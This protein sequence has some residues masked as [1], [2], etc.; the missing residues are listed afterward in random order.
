MTTLTASQSSVAEGETVRFNMLSDLSPVSL[1]Q[2]GSS[3]FA[4]YDITGGVSADDYEFAG[5]GSSD[6]QL[7]G[8][9][10]L[11]CSVS[12][13]FLIDL[14]VDDG[15]RLVFRWTGIRRVDSDG[16]SHVHDTFS[17]PLTTT[18]TVAHT[19]PTVSLSACVYNGVAGCVPNT[20]G[21]SFSVQEAQVYLISLNFDST[22]PVLGAYSYA[23]SGDDIT[24]EDY[25]AS[26][27][28]GVISRTRGG[29]FSAFINLRTD[30]LNEGRETLVYSLTETPFNISIGNS[31]T[32]NI[33]PSDPTTVRIARKSGE[34]G[35]VDE[36]G[37]GR[38][39]VT[40]VG[41]RPTAD[42][43][44]PFTIAGQATAVSPLTITALAT[45][46]EIAV[47][48]TRDANL[49]SGEE[50][51]I[52]LDAPDEDGNGGPS[53]GG[54]GGI[55]VDADND[56]A[57]A[58]IIDTATVGIAAVAAEVDEPGTAR[59]L[60]SY[61]GGRPAVGA[62]AVNVTV[63]YTV[64]G[65]AAAADYTDAGGG[66][67]TFAAGAADAARTI[68]I[69]VVD[70]SLA[71]IEET[72]TVTLATATIGVGKISIQPAAASAG[73]TIEANDGLDFSVRFIEVTDRSGS[74]RFREVTEIDEGWG[75]TLLVC[76]RGGQQFATDAFV[77][78]RLAGSATRGTS[79]DYTLAPNR[80]VADLV[81]PGR[82][83]YLIARSEFPCIEY[84]GTGSAYPYLRV[85]NDSD[86]EGP[87][88][89]TATITRVSI[90]PAMFP[91][92]SAAPATLT[93]RRSDPVTLSADLCS[94]PPPAACSVTALPVVVEGSQFYIVL[95]IDEA[96]IGLGA[97]VTVN[98]AFSGDYVTASD[99]TD[100]NA[101]AFTLAAGTPAD[102][103]YFA[104][105]VANENLAEGP[106]QIIVTITSASGASEVS[107]NADNATH[108]VLVPAND[109]LR[110][111]VTPVKTE[112]AEGSTAQFTF[113]AFGD[114]ALSR[115]NVP[116]V[117]RGTYE[118]ATES[119]QDA[120]ISSCPPPGSSVAIR[121]FCSSIHDIEIPTDNI[122]ENDETLTVA[123]GGDNQNS[124]TVTI[125]DATN[126]A[127]SIAAPAG[128]VAEG[129]SAEFPLSFNLAEGLVLAE[130]VTILYTFA[131]AAVTSGGGRITIATGGD[132]GAIS[133]A[134]PDDNLN[135]AA[136][137][138]TV[139][140][141]AVTGA[142]VAAGEAEAEATVA[143]SDPITV[144]IARK[145]GE[146]G[147]INEGGVARFTVTLGGGTP[148]AN[149]TVPFTLSGSSATAS[150][151]SPL[152]LTAPAVSGEIVVTST[153]DTRLESGESLTIT[154]DTPDEEGAGGPGG[155][156]GGGISVDA[157][158]DSVTVA[159]TDD[160][161]ATV[162]IARTDAD[163]FT[164]GGAG[165][166]AT[167]VF[168]VT[169]TGATLSAAAEAAFTVT[170]VAGDDFTVSP[171]SPLSIAAGTAS[172]DITVAARDDSLNE[173][174]ETVTVTLTA[175]S[176]VG[177]ISVD[178]DNNQAT[179]V[180]ADNDAIAVTITRVGTATRAESI[181]NVEF[182]VALSGGIRTT[183]VT[184]PFTVGGTGIT[185][186]DYSVG[187]TT[188]TF[189][190]PN[191]GGTPP[192]NP[193]ATD[194]MT[195][196]IAIRDDEVNEA[197][198]TLT[199]TGTA[200][201]STGLR[202]A[203]GGGD[204]GYT[205]NNAN[206]IIG[207]EAS[208]VISQNDDITVT[209]ARTTPASGNV[210]E[211]GAVTFTVT[212][213]GASQG[214]VDVPW[215]AAIQTQAN[216]GNANTVT[217]PDLTFGSVTPTNNGG[218]V[219][220][221]VTIAAGA[222]E[223]TFSVT[224]AADG[225]AEGEETFR[226]SIAAPTAGSGAGSIT[227]GATTHAD[228][229]INA[230]AAVAHF[231]SV[232]GPDSAV[233]EGGDAVFTFS[234]PAIAGSNARTADL[235]VAYTLGGSADG[236]VST[237]TTR[238]YTTPTTLSVTFTA[239]ETEKTVTINTNDDSLNEAAE[240]ITV[241]L[242]AIT[243]AA[244]FNSVGGAGV[245]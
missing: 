26:G 79:G 92:T 127:V 88:T 198:E 112:V 145:S 158:N 41:G 222:T 27:P 65:T 113:F 12:L 69:S 7:T 2:D 176:S 155:G 190:A 221:T 36:G 82:D 204:I 107:I 35:A 95:S 134:V 138:L 3:Y 61:D 179:A 208:V 47:T 239:A 219:A 93:I 110:F 19:L 231:V 62:S 224:V 114:A 44:V 152:T 68:S 96:G 11:A 202:V 94:S 120:A 153:E 57:T 104:V 223:G 80:N 71:E 173:A 76:A 18:V 1:P 51:T 142:A 91:T 20:S 206:E 175:V 139:T 132:S 56:E 123:I 182:T 209:I 32:F 48:A 14:E 143:A 148:A 121:G 87:E 235:T 163:A 156:G 46:G 33:A 137:A 230:N 124:A 181:G 70:D 28:N 242:G 29:L 66:S 133:I 151:A 170:G 166:A 49:E 40:L 22:G 238:D 45:S 227:L 101:G 52:T 236:D 16:Q 42:V 9:P 160:E 99:Y 83:G 203:T 192:V 55:S 216:S 183:A 245:S 63:T 59:F 122:V 194:S 185:S 146:S 205:R 126:L 73:V 161:T 144:A 117:V 188:V 207:D 178:D 154:L 72:L 237:V 24:P 234:L 210:D 4:V 214:S 34:T 240:T 168:T 220:G 128:T 232:S 119:L 89:I 193:T 54:G 75:G 118:G 38:F 215:S 17:T 213:S 241:Q 172:A 64:G 37:M 212:L 30:G 243:N 226:A 105:T 164:E 8:A 157:D 200:A 177:S 21:T 187:S 90:E 125:T 171:A 184:M 180:L 116:Y 233:T 25:F 78:F 84:L 5:S 141:A 23:V 186:S 39:T 115:Y 77:E 167:A 199:V 85:R 108:R 189:P 60:L 106:E 10:V 103:R 58:A 136:S 130:D 191:P 111:A 135:E 218:T 244:S 162:A 217:M 131:G 15:E 43:T 201:G 150:P 98:Y 149:V 195:I 86:H 100:A 196:T 174:A 74:E 53:G 13:T 228:V 165:P 102:Q 229:T 81:M 97:D 211:G 140:L 6:C 225:L 67:F 31:L 169:V 197:D 159:V 147:A 109:G 50:F 129:G